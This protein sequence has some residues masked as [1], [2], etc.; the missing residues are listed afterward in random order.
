MERLKYKFSALLLFYSLFFTQLVNADDRLTLKIGVAKQGWAPFELIEYGQP[1]GYLIDYLNLVAQ[2]GHFDIKWHIVEDRFELLQAGKSGQHDLTYGAKVDKY[3]EHFSF[4]KVIIPRFIGAFTYKGQNINQLTPDNI[5]KLR[6][7]APASFQTTRLFKEHYP[8]AQYIETT[9]IKEALFQVAS[10]KADVVFT[11]IAAAMYNINESLL[12]D[13]EVSLAPDFL[14]QHYKPIHLL[15][16]K[17]VSPELKQRVESARDKI[18]SSELT[19]LREKWRLISSAKTN[20]L[21]LS[22]EEVDWISNAPTIR[23]AAYENLPPFSFEKKGQL[24]G[25][26]I[27]YLQMLSK[28]TGLKFEFISGQTWT[29]QIQQAEDR[30]IDMLQLVRQRDDLARYMN[31]SHSYLA[32]SPIVLYGKSNIEQI[33]N[34]NELQEKKL[35]VHRN[36]VQQRYLSRHYPNLPIV[37]VDNTEEGINLLLRG[38]VD[39]FL[40]STTSCDTYIY[41]NFI[42]N[43][44]VVGHL[45]IDEFSKTQEARLAVRADWPLL[46]SIIDKTIQSITSEQVRSL[47]QKWLSNSNRKQL[48]VETLT[49]HETT[50]LKTHRRLAF[51]LPLKLAPFAFVEE[52]QAKGIATDMIQRFESEYGVDAHYVHHSSWTDIVNA[53]MTGEIDFVPSMNITEKRK[54]KLLFTIP[55]LYMQAVIFTQKGSQRITDLQ[56]ASNKKLGI[57]KNSAWLAD[58][59]EDFPE[60]EVVEFSKLDDVFEALSAGTV[61]FTVNSALAS[62]YHLKALGITN[63]EET[64]TTSYRQPIA[65]AV[66]PSNPELVTLFNKLIASMDS[67]DFQLILEKWNNLQVVQK[68]DWRVISFWILG[69]VSFLFICFFIINIFKR[70]AT[71]TMLTKA[72]KRLENAQRVA[73]IGSWDIDSENRLTELS[74]EAAAILAVAQSK[75]LSRTEYVQ[76]IVEEDRPQY[77]EGWNNALKTGLFNCEYRLY[78]GDSNKWVNEIAEIE[79][80]KNG[81]LIS[82]SAVIQ[83]ISLFKQSQLE[84][85]NHQEELRG[86]TSKLLSVQEEERRRV[87]RE[88]HD[89]LSQRLAVISIDAGTLEMSVNEDAIKQPLRKIK[90]GL[91]SIAEDTHSLSRRLHPSILDDL[92]LIAALQSEVESFQ[93]RE[94]IK[95][96]L[97][98]S[99]KSLPLSKEADLA[100]FR[101]VQEAL[102]NIAKYSEASLV[103][104][105]LT[106]IKSVLILQIIDDGMGF[107][108]IEAKRAPG[109]GLQSMMERAKLVGG[110]LTID[111][112]E[113][114]GTSIELHLGINE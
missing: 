6:I 3:R 100:V 39:Y 46:S 108:I 62:E 64:G 4:G 50:W 88:L 79:F 82:G 106:V 8:N 55:Y 23:V 35:A 72:S 21:Q 87:A 17:E 70:K 9:D 57:V 101:I 29:E 65:I 7:A 105:N 86:L 104:V 96:D 54:E 41:Q 102:R 38:E 92:G 61:D 2:K 14:L 71:L 20:K 73:K 110:E 89:D 13:I 36:Y 37:L 98:C 109:L 78:Q 16:S 5:S 76:M 28:K 107:D 112:T 59:K 15:Y 99:V 44:N 40:C 91:I 1:S 90:Q 97:F 33:T 95:V 93:R 12:P 75:T 52:Q 30:N 31:F 43:L 32:G 74:N 45:G 67:D 47:K 26:S 63:I 58:I 56:Q 34:I 103:K 80:D 94:E 114:K 68:N 60:I 25:Y 48:I 11:D 83:D 53:V 77:L 18:T 81:L 85:L 42:S 24:V 66:H 22:S 113:N 19:S 10:G 27:D 51:S 49:E 111:S 84:L 69:V